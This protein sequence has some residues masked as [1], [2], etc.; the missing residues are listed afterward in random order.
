M[1]RGHSDLQSD[2]LPLSYAPLIIMRKKV[3]KKNNHVKWWVKLERSSSS[4]D[5]FM[6]EIKQFL[7]RK[8]C[9][10]LSLTQF[11]KSISENKIE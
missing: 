2:A 5:D 4:V 9:Q 8:L 11:N 1:I 6:E 10:R 7:F 3:K